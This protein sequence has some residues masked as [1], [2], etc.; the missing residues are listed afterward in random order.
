M[1]E[2]H[3]GGAD[4]VLL[5]LPGALM[6]PQHMIEGGLFAR[7]QQHPLKLDLVAPDLHA[8]LIDNREAL[9]WLHSEWLL[10][11]R[12]RYRQL[13]LGGISRG[14]QLALAAWTQGRVVLD[15]LCLLAPYAGSRITTNAIVR[16]GGLAGWCPASE[17]LRD[18]DVRLWHAL[19][20]PP[21]APP[22]FM[23]Y[24]E[25]DRFA[26]GMALLAQHLP[27]TRREC[28]AGG[29]DWDA[30]RPLWGRFLDAFEGLCGPETDRGVAQ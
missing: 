27:L 12:E 5:M 20:S 28:V 4:A 14:G 10:P 1:V 23:G 19:Q 8:G 3:L 25:D 29:H 6:T 13:W 15:G 21:P 17:Q 16:S 18:P 2:R 26:D 11:L 30:W 22:M 7:L 24:G 9:D